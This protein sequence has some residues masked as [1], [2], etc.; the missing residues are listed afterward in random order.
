[1]TVELKHLVIS[2]PLAVID[3][4]STGV[5]PATDRIVEVAVLTLAPGRAAE[6]FHTRINPGCPIPAAATAVHHIADADVVDAPTFETVA[7]DLARTLDGCDLAGFGI[8]GFDVPLLCAA[9]ARAG[10]PFELAGRAVVD[11]LTVY[12]HYE[13]RTLSA[14]VEQYLGRPH[15]GAHSACADARAALEVLDAQVGR[16]GLPPAPGALHALFSGVDLA[17]KFRRAD[18]RVEFAFGKH[19][20]RP[21]ADVAGSDRGY[22]EWMLTRPFLPD[23][24][25]L[26]RAV[27]AVGR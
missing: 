14:A 8:T 1:M 4:E 23:V 3:L 21:L 13:P 18:G 11:A 17:G 5:D 10:V 26:V 15:A 7:A 2:R 9:F 25:A 24:H 6:M 16:Y 22:L 20:G 12:R 27:L 19:R